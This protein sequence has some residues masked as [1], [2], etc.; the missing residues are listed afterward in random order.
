MHLTWYG[1][2]AFLL[3]GTP[4]TDTSSASVR[5]VLDPYRAPDVGTY[6]PIDDWAD[7][8][9]I[10]HE[11]AKYH[12]HIEGIRGREAGAKPTVVDG[13]ALL[14]ANETGATTVA[15][16]P[17]CAFRVWENDE[18]RE[19]IA[20]LHVTVGG[21]SFLHMGDCGHALSSDDTHRLI[22]AVGPV[23]VLLALAG[24]PPTLAV[25]DLAAFIRDLSPRLVVPMHF[26]ND[27]INLNLRP[28]DDLL[29][30]CAPNTVRHLPAPTVEITPPLLPS[31]TE[32]WLMPPAR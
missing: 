26:G 10:S 14:G 15:G 19:P 17:F 18:R 30:H 29:Q 4:G 23:D 22:D 25:D 3:D 16:V 27:K 24:G 20:M 12:S 5:V 2:A 21:V 9:A 6:A 8:V 11:N 7:I 1:H 28:V 31:T 32:I 13:L